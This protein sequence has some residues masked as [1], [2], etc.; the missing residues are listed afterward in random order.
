MVGRTDVYGVC[1]LGLLTVFPVFGREFELE[2]IDEEICLG[3]RFFGL[4]EP[5]VEDGFLEL[6]LLRELDG[7]FLLPP[8]RLICELLFLVAIWIPPS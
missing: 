8:D 3:G 4:L 5:L 6:T 1:E 2:L 7:R